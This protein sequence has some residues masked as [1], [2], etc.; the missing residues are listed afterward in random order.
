[1]TVPLILL[2]VGAVLA[3]CVFARATS[4]ARTG[5]SSGAARSS[6]AP[7]N[8]VLRRAWSTCR[9]LI[10][11]LPTVIGLLGIALAYLFYMVP[12]PAG[13]ARGD[14]SRPIYRFLLNKWYFDE[15]YDFL[16]VR[17]AQRLARVLWQVGDATIIDGMP[18]GAR[19]ADRGRLG[20]GGAD[21]D[22]L[23]RGLRL[24]H[25]D[26]PRRA[27]QRLPALRGERRRMN[28]AGFP[29][30]LAAHLAAAGRRAS[31]S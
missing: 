1:M 11:L 31:S 25:A 12:G 4:S 27:G 20:A 29:D 30:P 24:H 15:L 18:N 17:P 2:A 8:H 23:D 28:A 19:R 22:R 21:P 9:W 10:A 3:G 14:A 5:R 7:S 13:A 6:S 16:F 26:R